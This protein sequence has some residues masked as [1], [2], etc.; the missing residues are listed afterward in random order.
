M[1]EPAGDGGEGAEPGEQGTGERGDTALSGQAAGAARRVPTSL[2]EIDLLRSGE[3]TG[4]PSLPVQR[5]GTWDYLVSVHRGGQGSRFEVW[6]IRLR[7]PLPTI[8]I[9]LAEGVP[10]VDLDRHTQAVFN[11]CCDEKSLWTAG[12][13]PGRAGSAPGAGGRRLGGGAAGGAPLAEF[14]TGR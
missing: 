13:L 8:R 9:P 11:R 2:V 12:E 5:R 3:H 4:G 7:D 6:P 10:D 14:E 1:G